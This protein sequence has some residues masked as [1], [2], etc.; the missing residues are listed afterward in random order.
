MHE[1]RIMHRDIKPE[2]IMLRNENGLQPV[3]VDFGLSADIDSDDYMFYRC[4]T[5][6]YVAPEVTTLTKGQK[7]NPECDIFSLGAIL[8][9]L[10]A[11]RPLFEGRKADQVYENNRKMKF[12]LSS[13]IYNNIDCEAIDLLRR[14]LKVNPEDRIKA[15]EILEHSFISG[16]AMDIEPEK[17]T[18]SPA[19]T[20]SSQGINFSQAER[21]F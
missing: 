13:P 7:I 19:T 12:D 9:I 14:M 15:S 10:L 5:P 17:Y 21:A 3:I 2:N 8:H 20:V 11:R 18:L 4:G 16:Y 1:Y 6:G